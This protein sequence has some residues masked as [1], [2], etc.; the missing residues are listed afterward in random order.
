MVSHEAVFGS[1][2]LDVLFCVEGC[3]ELGGIVCGNLGGNDGNG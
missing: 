1:S 3:Y 2:D